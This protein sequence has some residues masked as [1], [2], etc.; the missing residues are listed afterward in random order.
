ML[1]LGGGRG[2][3]DTFLEPAALPTLVGRM[4]GNVSEGPPLVDGK[5]EEHFVDI[6]CLAEGRLPGCVAQLMRLFHQLAHSLSLFSASSI[7]AAMTSG[8]V[9]PL[10][11]GERVVAVLETGAPTVT[12]KL[13][14]LR[15]A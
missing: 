4:G 6:C 12:Y 2:E 10:A 3:V 5:G 9:D 14:T 7:L 15:A 1:L 13:A 11:L 8:A